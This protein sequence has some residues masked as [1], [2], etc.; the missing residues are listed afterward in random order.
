MRKGEK[1]SGFFFGV[2]GGR[3]IGT[4]IVPDGAPKIFM[5]ALERKVYD[6]RTVEGAP[7]R[8][9]ISRV[10]EAEQK[11]LAEENFIGIAIRGS[12]GK[13]YSNKYSNTDLIVFFD[14]PIILIPDTMNSDSFDEINNFYDR[15]RKSIG[16]AKVDVNFHNLSLLKEG[17]Y[18]RTGNIFRLT[19]GKKINS[20]RDYWARK[21]NEQ[22]IDE[23]EISITLMAY[24]LAQDDIQGY[25]K[26]TERVSEAPDRE[27][28]LAKRKA[29]W[30][31]R[32]KRF[33]ERTKR[34]DLKKSLVKI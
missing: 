7:N 31:A 3:Q 18:P 12:L 22:G 4:N 27:E 9:G 20:Y 30:T 28:A 25:G 24:Y 16:S 8:E 6:L 13:G 23:Q 2:N 5:I 11:L 34:E 29:L 32:I 19:T 26:I 17:I 15:V 21:I 10:R 14:I 1:E 33:L